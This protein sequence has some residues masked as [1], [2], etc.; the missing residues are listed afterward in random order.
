MTMIPRDDAV[1]AAQ[2][3]EPVLLQTLTRGLQAL[4]IIATSNGRATAKSVARQLG[5]RPG[6]CYHLLRTLLAGGYIARGDNGTYDVGPYGGRLGHH[7]E[8]RF[9][10]LPEISA[11]LMRL[12]NRTGET[13]YV[14]GWNRGTIVMR[15]FIRG[16]GPVAVGNLDV[17]YSAHLHARASCLSILAFLPRELVG[18]MMSGSEMARLTSNTVQSYPQLVKRLDEVHRTGYSLDNEEFVEGVCCVSAPF[19]QADDQPIGS[20]TVSVPQSRFA[21]QREA[22]VSAV[23]EAAALATR[24]SKTGRLGA[25]ET[26]SNNAPPEI[27]AQGLR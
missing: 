6:T 3:N 13:A 7:L 1:E 21:T 23:L 18:T 27:Q 24:L 14:S 10:P 12:R 15:Q 9:G 8:D 17:G 5:I 11:L 25:P 4:D 19:F 2:G 22:L 20:L 26:G 16:S